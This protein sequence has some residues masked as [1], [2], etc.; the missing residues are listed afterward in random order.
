MMAC[1]IM[2]AVAAVVAAIILA[3]IPGTQLLAAACIA[4][5]VGLYHVMRQGISTHDLGM[6]GRNKDREEA[7][8]NR[9][10]FYR[11]VG[12]LAIAWAGA[13]M[14]SASSASTAAQGA[15]AVSSAAKAADAVSV[16]AKIAEGLSVGQK[17]VLAAMRFALNVGV[18]A[19]AGVKG[20]ALVQVAVVSGCEQCAQREQWRG[21]SNND[22]DGRGISS[23]GDDRST[24]GCPFCQG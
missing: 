14:S 7:K 19:A 16:G 4:A 8:Q 22:D 21:E 5:A 15:N 13:A 2:V 24:G 3:I 6:F 20:K 9:A 11:A 18:A 17:V 10:G 12:E 1:D 23:G